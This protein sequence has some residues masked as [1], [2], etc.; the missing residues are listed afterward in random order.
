MNSTPSQLKM[1]YG[2]CP[3]KLEARFQT[4]ISTYRNHYKK[5]S[6]PKGTQYWS[7]CGRCSYKI[8]QIEENC[9]PDQLIK[10]QFIK[11]EQFYGV[12]INPE[13]HEFNK[14]SDSKMYWFLGDFY[15]QMVEFSNHN[16][17]NP[18]IVNADM[19]LMPKCGVE[20]LSKIMHFLTSIKTVPIMLVGNFIMKTRQHVASPIDIVRGLEKEPLFQDS[21]NSKKWQIH[22]MFYTYNGTGKTRTKMGTV[23]LFKQ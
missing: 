4:I 9:E 12:E 1:H 22:P 6:I 2:A 13:I 11:P 23:I 5:N 19:L 21:M 3:K 7:I 16:K 8:G 15:E 10:A 14:N 20:Y 17:F 18:S